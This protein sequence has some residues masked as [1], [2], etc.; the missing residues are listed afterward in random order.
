MKRILIT[1][2][3]I[4]SFI[5]SGCI[6]KNQTHF[7]DDTSLSDYTLNR[8]LTISAVTDD[9][10]GFTLIPKEALNGNFN[11]NI[12]YL[13]LT[14]VT[15]EI[16][17]TTYPLADAIRDG[18]ITVEEI[19]A[20]ARL[21]AR[22]GI[23][24]ELYES[25][26]GLTIFTYRY[27]EFDLSLTY[28]VYE[29][30]DGEQHLI[31]N[32][33]LYKVGSNV[34][35]TYI[36]DETGKIIDHEDWGLT[37]DAVDATPTTLTVDCTQSGGQHIGELVLDFYTLFNVNTN[38]PI[39]HLEHIKSTDQYQPKITIEQNT[40]SQFTIDWTDTHAPLPSGEYYIWLHVKDVFEPSQVHPLM[41][42]FYSEQYFTV[43]FE[44]P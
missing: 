21:D 37:F 3:I 1:L 29:T 18:L 22:N 8:R 20:Y 23:C 6:L 25:K 28:D 10:A 24:S 42:D 13:D 27:P 39:G 30:P 9:E 33:Q 17:G 41:K 31:N 26:N 34:S 11:E 16:T 12:A 2:I 44:I 5:L 43:T 35:H 38:D 32:L 14:D 36:D 4:F 15:V 7:V 19:F 40:T